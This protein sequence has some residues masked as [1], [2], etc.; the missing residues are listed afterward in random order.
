L[1]FF[2]FSPSALDQ[3][4]LAGLLGEQVPLLP[5]PPKTAPEENDLP[6]RWALEAVKVAYQQAHSGAPEARGQKVGSTDAT[7]R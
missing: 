7:T 4:V 1:V 3:Q 5:A 2:D 6:S